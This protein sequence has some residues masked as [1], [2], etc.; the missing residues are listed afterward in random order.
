LIKLIS[1]LFT[2][3]GKNMDD[4]FVSEE[5]VMSKIYSIRNEKVMLDLDLAELYGVE[6]K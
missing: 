3:K 2:I 6:N 4:R 5:V 1:S